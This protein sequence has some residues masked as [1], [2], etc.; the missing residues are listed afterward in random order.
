MTFFSVFK[1]VFMF[2]NSTIFYTQNFK[3]KLSQ[4][5]EIDYE[6]SIFDE[7]SDRKLLNSTK[8]RF[9]TWGFGGVLAEF[10]GGLVSLSA[11]ILV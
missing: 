9:L 4:N 6:T 8:S 11:L 3:V 5:S 7:I 1:R 10:G 2:L